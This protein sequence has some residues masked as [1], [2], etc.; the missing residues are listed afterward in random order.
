MIDQI[1][2]LLYDDDDVEGSLILVVIFY[3]RWNNIK[4]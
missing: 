3:F 1:R 2:E 4:Y